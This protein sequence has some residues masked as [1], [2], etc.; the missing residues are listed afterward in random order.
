MR[1]LVQYK[2]TSISGVLAAS[3][4]MA[5]SLMMEAVTTSETSVNFYQTTTLCCHENF[6]SKKLK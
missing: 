4:S 2:F 5:F 3:I 6:K 1:H